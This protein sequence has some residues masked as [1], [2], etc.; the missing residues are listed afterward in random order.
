MARA[1]LRVVNDEPTHVTDVSEL[2]DIYVICRTVGHSWDDDPTGEWNTI[3]GWTMQLRCTR[4]T[5]QKLEAINNLGE[6]MARHYRYPNGYR[7]VRDRPGDRLHR[8]DF[9]AELMRRRIIAR[10]VTKRG[11]QT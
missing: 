7:V 6:V 3:F 9:R 1:N 4:C 8:H 10:R 11:K 5:T 2:L